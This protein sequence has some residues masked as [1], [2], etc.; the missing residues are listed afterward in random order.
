MKPKVNESPTRAF[1]ALR[2]DDGIHAFSNVFVGEVYA[3]VSGERCPKLRLC[4][5]LPT[6]C[7]VQHVLEANSR[8]RATRVAGKSV[9]NLV[10]LPA[11][12][13][14]LPRLDWLDGRHDT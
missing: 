3:K 1:G 6:P 8:V 4:I 13:E 10:G 11:I 9:V 7:S 14:W 12:E 5:L 2:Y